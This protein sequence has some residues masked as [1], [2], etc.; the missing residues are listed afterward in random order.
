[1]TAI[2]AKRLRYN[3][4]LFVSLIIPGAAEMSRRGDEGGAAGRKSLNTSAPN[5]RKRVR[6]VE[7]P[8]N[9]VVVDDRFRK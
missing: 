7:L 5:Y 8:S 1:M 3:R 6:N 2:M 9:T 4:C